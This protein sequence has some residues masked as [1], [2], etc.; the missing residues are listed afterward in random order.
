MVNAFTVDVEDY[1]QVSAMAPY[2][3][4]DQWEQR[5]CRVERNMDR[6]L[7]MLAEHDTKATFFVLGWLAERYPQL[8]RRIVEN[9]H[10]AA[11]HGY[12]HERA[13]EL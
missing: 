11:S 1:F 12:G 13:N 6:I 9:G 10:E 7:F 8:L 5:E 2:I 3:A 4:R